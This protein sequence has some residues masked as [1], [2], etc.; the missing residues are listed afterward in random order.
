MNKTIV[1]YADPLSV[2]A[3]DILNVFVSC[4]VPGDYR[5]ELVRLIS[6]DAR[7]HG[8]GFKE[9]SVESTFAGVYPGR[10]QELV[11]G[12]YA[13]LPAVPAT[14]AF[15]F[16]CYFYPTLLEDAEQTLVHGAGCSVRLS[17]AG[18]AVNVD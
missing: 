5:A 15:A 16:G 7:P 4:D 11:T 3:G 13:V 1:A 9:V 12:S 6:G 10:H 14:E 17:S 8:T 2:C 18:I